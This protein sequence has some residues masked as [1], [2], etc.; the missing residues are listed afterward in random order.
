MYC[1]SFSISRSVCLIVTNVSTYRPTRRHTKV[2]ARD[3]KKKLTALQYYNTGV[4]ILQSERK[5]GETIVSGRRQKLVFVE[6]INQRN[7]KKRPFHR[8]KW[9]KKA[10]I[11]VRNIAHTTS[12]TEWLY[13]FITQ[14]LYIFP[15]RPRRLTQNIH[16]S[17]AKEEC[18][19]A[20]M[21]I[22]LP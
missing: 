2:R 22:H 4:A 18:H 1:F 10:L 11:W 20:H 16:A 8:G 5:N 13:C 7:N 21:H 15:C 12:R 6:E 17:Q 9:A 14:M 19:I 3:Y